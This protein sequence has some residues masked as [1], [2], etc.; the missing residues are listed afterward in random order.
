V[1]PA[2]RSL[3]TGAV[4]AAAA[5]LASLDVVHHLTAQQEAAV[6]AL[7]VETLLASGHVEDAV[8]AAPSL[9][10]RLVHAGGPATTQVA[11]TLHLAL[12]QVEEAAGDHGGALSHFTAAG[13]AGGDDALR[14]W[15]T[16][17]AVALVRTGRR[18]EAA[19]LTLEQVEVATLAH[20]D[21]ALAIGLRTLAVTGPTQRPIETLRRARTLAVGTG[22]RRLAAQIDT[23]LAALLLLSG[24]PDTAEPLALLRAAETY[25]REEGLWPSHARA[26]RLLGRLGETPR[27]EVDESL[28]Q[29]TPA[30]RRVARLAAGGLTNR[31]IA[32]RLLVTVKGVEWHL[33]RVYKKLGISSRTRLS[34]IFPQAS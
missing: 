16:G 7:R 19:T 15:R 17:A 22:D 30:E 10:R 31:E 18:R 14:P 29:L 23:D 5:Q 9:K 26:L 1:A 2:W 28:A 33:S 24:A 27:P 6:A 12:G 34:G 25:T 8:V 20:D 11:T 4:R 21:R 32:E 3:R 13:L